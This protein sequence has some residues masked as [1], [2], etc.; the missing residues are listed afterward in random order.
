MKCF[1][2][3]AGV[4]AATA[5]TVSLSY[6]PKYDNAGLNVLDLACSDGPNGMATKSVNASQRPM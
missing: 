1:N 6:D 2:I 5:A 4:A 3:L